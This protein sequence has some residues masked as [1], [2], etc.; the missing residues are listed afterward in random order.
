MYSKIVIVGNLGSDPELRYT[1]QGDG[2][3]SI[4]CS[5]QRRWTGNDGQPGEETT[6]FKSIGL[7][8]A[9]RKL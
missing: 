4:Q 5:H 2:V 3:C 8:Q 1:P 9:G 7:G 6:W